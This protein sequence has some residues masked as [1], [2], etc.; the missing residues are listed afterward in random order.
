MPNIFSPQSMKP[1]GPKR[2][3]EVGNLEPNPLWR[4]LPCLPFSTFQCPGIPFCLGR[5]LTGRYFQNTASDL[6]KSRDVGNTTTAVSTRKAYKP[7]QTHFGPQN[8]KGFLQINTGLPLP[9]IFTLMV[10]LCN[11]VTRHPLTKDWVLSPYLEA[12]KLR[13]TEDELVES[14]QRQFMMS[15]LCQVLRKIKV[16]DQWPFITGCLHGLSWADSQCKTSLLA[17]ISVC[18]HWHVGAFASRL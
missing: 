8:L 3:V 4:D 9:F 13:S 5:L 10:L 15:Y 7:Q 17:S 11:L 14:G 1:L 2:E 16:N 12:G 6:P 18:V